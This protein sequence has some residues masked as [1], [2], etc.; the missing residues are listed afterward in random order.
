MEKDFEYNIYVGASS[1]FDKVNLLD[2]V[3]NENH[4]C[5]FLT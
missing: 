4:F 1:G 3:I 2:Y 5:L